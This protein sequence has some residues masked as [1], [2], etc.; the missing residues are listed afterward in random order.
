MSFCDVL[1]LDQEFRELLKK[2]WGFESKPHVKEF[3]DYALGQALLFK[4]VFDKT[5]DIRDTEKVYLDVEARQLEK[6]KSL[7]LP[8]ALSEA[9]YN[10][11]VI[12]SVCRRL[13][14]RHKSIEKAFWAVH[15]EDA[16]RG[17]DQKLLAMETLTDQKIK[18]FIS[19]QPYENKKILVADLVKR[20]ILIDSEAVELLNVENK[21]EQYEGVV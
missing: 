13:V 10:L 7:L 16:L 11:A 15:K 21:K 2:V 3:L 8:D 4:S 18:D 9:K 14:E 19:R 20:G 17:L 1:V 12:K 5:V 6:A